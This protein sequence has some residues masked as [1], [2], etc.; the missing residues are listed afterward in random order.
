MD[1]STANFI[2][3]LAFIFIMVFWIIKIFLM[4][5]EE[6]HKKVQEDKE[7]TSN[8]IKEGIRKSKIYGT[9]KSRKRN[10]PYF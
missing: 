2:V 6:L 7:R 3:F 1:N 8:R 10:W 9:K 4:S 5:D